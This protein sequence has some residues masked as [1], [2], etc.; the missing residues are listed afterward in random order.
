M[1]FSLDSGAAQTI[2]Q[3]L[4]RIN[5]GMLVVAMQSFVNHSKSIGR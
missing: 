5:E 3:R 4:T 2:A 1:Y